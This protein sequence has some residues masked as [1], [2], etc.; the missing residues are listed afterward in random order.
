MCVSDVMHDEKEENIRR[1]FS[2]DKD[3]VEDIVSNNNI[4]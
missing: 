3:I 4:Q 2:D 1:M